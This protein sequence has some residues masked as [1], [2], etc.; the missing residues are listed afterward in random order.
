MARIETITMSMRELDR[1]KVIQTLVDGRL[2]PGHAAARLGLTVRR[3]HR[4]VMRHNA[5]GPA[6]LVS[7]RLNRPSNHQADEEIAQVA[8]I[9][10]QLWPDAGLREAARTAWH[11]GHM[12]RVGQDRHSH[13]QPADNRAA[14]W[15]ILLAG[16][17]EAKRHRNHADDHGERGHQHRPQANAP[18]IDHRA[19]WP[20]F[21]TGAQIV[22]EA[23]HQN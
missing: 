6:V 2:K 17:T 14:K 16:F 19:Q 7:R 4:L 15:R 18:G 5:E 20:N 22:G 21:L 3:V 8:L 11:C 9:L 23:H 13:N 10:I 1:L 12:P